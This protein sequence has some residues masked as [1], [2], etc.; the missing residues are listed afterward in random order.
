MAKVWVVS[1]SNKPVEVYP[2]DNAAFLTTWA[3]DKAEA[4]ENDVVVEESGDFY[5]ID[6]WMSASLVELS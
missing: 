4:L 5:Y 3:A 1:W 6:G 2:E